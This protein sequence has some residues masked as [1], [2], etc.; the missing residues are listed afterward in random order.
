M[1]EY[2]WGFEAILD[3]VIFI[4]LVKDV[5]LQMDQDKKTI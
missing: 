5:V 3:S 1:K 4:L 2:L